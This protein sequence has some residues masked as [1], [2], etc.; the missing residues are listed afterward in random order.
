MLRSPPAAPL[1]S[2]NLVLV[3]YPALCAS[4]IGKSTPSWEILLLPQMELGPSGESYQFG[5][6]LEKSR[7]NA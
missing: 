6:H 5:Q 7:R 2:Q 3:L 4:G 1:Q